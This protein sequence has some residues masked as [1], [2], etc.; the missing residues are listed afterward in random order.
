VGTG[1]Q[2]S[3]LEVVVVRSDRA[4]VAVRRVLEVA[5]GPRTAL[6]ADRHCDTVRSQRDDHRHQGRERWARR[7]LKLA[8]KR[9][10]KRLD[11]RGTAD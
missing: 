8:R 9:P 1:R 4:S 11:E 7:R 2:G 3:H 6:E 10:E 5:H